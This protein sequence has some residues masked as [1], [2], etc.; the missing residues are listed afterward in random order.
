MAPINSIESQV[1]C[2]L[3][4]PL[5]IV[6]E[7]ARMEMSNLTQTKLVKNV[8]HMSHYKRMEQ[9]WLWHDGV[10]P[11][12]VIK[13]HHIQLPNYICL[14]NRH[15]VDSSEVFHI[16]YIKYTVTYYYLQ[17]AISLYWKCFELNQAMILKKLRKN[18]KLDIR[19]EII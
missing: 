11:N 17:R 7:S 9:D 18:F 13:I 4:K 3:K 14:I 16:F 12:T 15:S 8:F 1:I 19:Y 10:N 6:T 5:I 2:I